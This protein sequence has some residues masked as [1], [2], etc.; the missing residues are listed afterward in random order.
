MARGTCD[1]GPAKAPR[2]PRE[3][4]RSLQGDTGEAGRQRAQSRIP[5]ANMG[6]DGLTGSRDPG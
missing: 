1:E 6:R 5:S 2:R 3:G 4:P